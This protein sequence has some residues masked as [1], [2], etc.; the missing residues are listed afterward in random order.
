M[1][2]IRQANATDL[3]VVRVLVFLD[4]MRTTRSAWI[5]FKGIVRLFTS[6]CIFL[7]KSY[8]NRQPFARGEERIYPAWY[9]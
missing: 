6:G 9:Q 1:Y 8:A 5:A 2:K 3:A 7:S 4:P